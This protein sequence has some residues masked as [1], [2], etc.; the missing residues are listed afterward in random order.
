MLN[1]KS[2]KKLAAAHLQSNLQMLNYGMN[3][4]KKL[5]QI[6]DSKHIRPKELAD[7]VDLAP[8]VISQYRSG[9]RKPGREMLLKFSKALDVTMDELVSRTE[10]EGSAKDETISIQE[11]KIMLV[12]K[13]FEKYGYDSVDAIIDI[14]PKLSAQIQSAKKSADKQSARL[15]QQQYEETLERLKIH[16][17]QRKKRP[18]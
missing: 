18:A 13:Q 15:P 1:E 7:R 14:I 8:S 4:S 17:R 9:H 2:T 16:R 10:F 5:R 12:R 6:M 11:Q 3:F